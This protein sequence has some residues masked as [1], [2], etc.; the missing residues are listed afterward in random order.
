MTNMPH[1]IHRGVSGRFTSRC[2]AFGSVNSSAMFLPA[3]RLGV[4]F[5]VS[6]FERS[7]PGLLRV[8]RIHR[9]LGFTLL[10]RDAFDL[11]RK[12]GSIR[13]VLSNGNTKSFGLE[14]SQVHLRRICLPR[15]RPTSP[16]SPYV[17]GYKCPRRHF[18]T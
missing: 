18:K 16:H 4:E 15:I 2:N 11:H 8:V 1:R 17:W 12:H 7:P 13:S 6:R 14:S 3:I 10:N 5:V 9:S